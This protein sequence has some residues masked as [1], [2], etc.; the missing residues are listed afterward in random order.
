MRLNSNQSKRD[1]Y[2]YGM[3]LG[4]ADETVKMGFKEKCQIHLCV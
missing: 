4:G 2:T 3:I 1:G